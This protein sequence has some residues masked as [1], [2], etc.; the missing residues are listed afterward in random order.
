MSLRKGEAC[1]RARHRLDVHDQTSHHCLRCRGCRRRGAAVIYQQLKPAPVVVIKPTHRHVPTQAK[2]WSGTLS[3]LYDTTFVR[4][5]D[6]IELN[7]VDF[8]F[9]NTAATDVVVHLVVTPGGLHKPAWLKASAFSVRSAATARFYTISV[10][11]APAGAAYDVTIR[12]DRLP[13]I[14]LGGTCAAAFDPAENA[15]GLYIFGPDGNFVIQL[16]P[17]APPPGHCFASVTTG[18]SAACQRARSRLTALRTLQADRL[19][20]ALRAHGRERTRLLAANTAA[21]ARERPALLADVAAAGA[22]ACNPRTPSTGH[23]L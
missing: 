4:A 16:L 5:S 18:V 22:G 19:R 15:L 8:A 11:I 6:Q 23:V 12:A 17:P 10:T 20:E 1:A 9:L 21:L 13:T 3:R 7:A 2:P 14:G